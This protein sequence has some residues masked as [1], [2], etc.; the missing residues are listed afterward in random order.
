M[1][2]GNML[3]VHIFKFLFPLLYQGLIFS[4]LVIFDLIFASDLRG[5]QLR[6]GEDLYFLGSEISDQS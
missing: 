4:E 5:D 3:H 1:L 6:V 2:G